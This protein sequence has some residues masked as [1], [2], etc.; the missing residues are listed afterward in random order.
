VAP[1]LAGTPIGAILVTKGMR[2]LER[3]P[4]LLLENRVE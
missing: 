4:D 2:E 3:V 1:P